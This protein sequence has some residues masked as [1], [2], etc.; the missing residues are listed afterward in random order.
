[1]SF[2]IHTRLAFYP[3]QGCKLV[4]VGQIGVTV[5]KNNSCDI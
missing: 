5:E 2:T 4:K 1:M 3:L